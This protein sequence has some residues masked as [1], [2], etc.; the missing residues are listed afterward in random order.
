M[1]LEYLMIEG[2]EL[3]LEMHSESD[4]MEPELEPDLV[5][6]TTEHMSLVIHIRLVLDYLLSVNPIS[7]YESLVRIYYLVD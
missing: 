3:E 4:L 6:G 7:Y 2:L 5:L 1:M